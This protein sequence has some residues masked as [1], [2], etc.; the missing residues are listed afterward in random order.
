MIKQ[1][2]LF[3]SIFLGL[4]LTV[5]L[6]TLLGSSAQAESP[7]NYADV[8]VRQQDGR[9]TMRRITF[10]TPIS[11]LVALQKSGL[12]VEQSDGLVC[13]IERLGCPV[14]DCFCACK[15]ASCVFWN[16]VHWQNDHWEAAEVGANQY[17]VTNG[18]IEG[19]AWGEW[20]STPSALTPQ[21][22][23]TQL[24]LT[25]LRTQQQADG[26]FPGFGGNVGSTLDS[27][28]A[29]V[30]ANEAVANWTGS[31]GQSMLDDLKTNGATFASRSAAGAG[32][33]VLGL[34]AA[35]QDPHNF[36]GLDG[37]SAIRKYYSPTVGAFGTSNWDQA[38]AILGLLSAHEAV[39]D[40]AIN[41]L[42]GRAVADG[43]WGYVVGGESDVD[44]TGL[45]IQA[46][47]AAKQPLTS[48][49]IVKGLAYIRSAQ[50]PDGGFATTP[51]ETIGNTNS[52]ALAIQAMLAVGQDPF[53]A[54]FKTD[55]GETPLSFLLKNQQFDGSFV[56]QTGTAGAELFATQQAIT[57]LRGKIFPYRR[58]MVYLPLIVN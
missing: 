58:Q 2:Q 43:G 42:S 50:T 19:W 12:T 45:V 5:S 57:A 34:T 29:I 51:Q 15:G 27:L 39:P 55:R 23:A 49:A 8:V 10:T 47:I 37:I 20:G 21:L 1:K 56:W 24:A 18:T 33:L 30:A 11:G 44:T 4:G 6:F 35:G 53:G 17:T 25:W 40:D 41:L 14:N 26:S 36:G 13:N 16:Y 46:L 54:G 3:L 52:T 28:L 48:T 9:M 31:S 22:T 7:F 38:M 32:K